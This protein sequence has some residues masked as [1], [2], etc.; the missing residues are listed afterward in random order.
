MKLLGD[1]LEKNR[2]SKHKDGR[3]AKA[4]S[5][6]CGEDDPPPVKTLLMIAVQCGSGSDAPEAVSGDCLREL[7]TNAFQ[8]CTRY[9]SRP[10]EST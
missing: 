9:N 4:E 3:T 10:G 7:A 1:R 8:A 2:E 5:Y 6:G